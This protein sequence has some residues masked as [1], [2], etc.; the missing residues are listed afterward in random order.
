MEN[1]VVEFLKEKLELMN[2]G[3]YDVAKERNIDADLLNKSQV[4]VSALSG[5]VF[6]EA[7]TIPY[8]IEI[9]TADIDMVMADFTKIGKLYNNKPYSRIIQEDE[10]DFQSYVM[11]P[12]FNTP[13]CMQ[14]SLEIGSDKYARIVCFVIVNEVENVNNIKQLKINGEIID[15]LSATYS[16]NAELATNR[17]SGEE[18]SK[19]KKKASSCSV[20]FRM[21]NKSGIFANKAIRVSA[22]LLPGNTPFNVDIILDNGIELSFKMIIGT[23]ILV[24][25]MGKLASTDIGMFLYD[26]RGDLSNA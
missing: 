12:I 18:L 11:T 14:Q 15:K 2:P 3:M 8:Q 7:S 26:D 5:S 1:G 19:S 6:E 13:V 20:S 17:I 23:Y 10:D 21:I 25:E 24:T 4:V 9:T 22:G 16:Y